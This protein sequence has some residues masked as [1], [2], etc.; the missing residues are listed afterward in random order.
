VFTAAWVGQFI[1]HGVFERRAPALKDNLVQG[2]SHD[3]VFP[4]AI[5][6]ASG[7]VIPTCLHGPL[8]L[9]PFPPVLAPTLPIVVFSQALISRHA[10]S[11]AVT[12]QPNNVL[13]NT[14]LICSSR[15][16]PFLRPPRDDVRGLWL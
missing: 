15:D 5:E 6:V 12:P 7:I 8:V 4:R 11:T 10:H 13:L 3:S 16:R 2:K 1:G 9:R 14:E